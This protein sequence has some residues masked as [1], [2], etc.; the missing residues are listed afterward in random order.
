[1]PND[2]VQT[3]T[4]MEVLFKRRF[5]SVTLILVPAGHHSI[6]NIKLIFF[7]E[8]LSG[9]K[10]NYA[11]S[12]VYSLGGVTEDFVA[13][14]AHTLNCQT[15]YFPF[16]YFGIPIKPNRLVHSDWLPFINKID[17]RLDSWKGTLLSRGGPS[18]T[19]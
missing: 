7:F 2:S 15:G 16:T 1:M 14:A 17:T 18:Y 4:Q 8:L 19:R 11:K 6:C 3:F 13:T 9:L 12:V 10:I 5:A